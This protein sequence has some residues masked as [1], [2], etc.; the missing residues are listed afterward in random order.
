ML[1]WF[2]DTLVA[3]S[4]KLLLS[5]VL[6][7][8]PWTEKICVRTKKSP[9]LKRWQSDTGIHH[10]WLC[11]HRKSFQLGDAKT[12]HGI[13]FIWCRPVLRFIC[14]HFW[15]KQSRTRAISC[16]QIKPI[17]I[18]LDVSITSLLLHLI[19]WLTVYFFDFPVFFIPHFRMDAILKFTPMLIYFRNIA[20]YAPEPHIII[21]RKSRL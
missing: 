15:L 21:R 16:H 14:V 17:K 12:R 8:C 1:N 13:A 19:V 5:F 9:S 10:S 3:A 7:L 6:L 18:Y 4:L 20:N 2:N 11:F